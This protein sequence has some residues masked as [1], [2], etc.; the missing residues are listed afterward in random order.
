MLTHL[1]IENFAIIKNT[2]VE[3]HKG[4]NIITGETGS[5]KSIVIEAI[6]IA[7]GGRASSNLVRN[8][9][10][11]AKVQ[12]RAE[13][14]GEEIIIIREISQKG[15]NLCKI[16]G[17]L[18]TVSEVSKIGSILADIHGQYD[19]QILLNQENHLRL[20]DTYGGSDL[21]DTMTK[22]TALFDDYNK[23]KKELEQILNSRQEQNNQ[24]D[25]WK[26]QL[27]E[28]NDARLLPLEDVDL[29]ES[30]KIMEHS[31]TIY[32]NAMNT[33]SLL[34]SDDGIL[35][36]LGK[37]SNYLEEIY[38]FSKD[39]EDIYSQI[40]EAYFS[41]QDL[42]YSLEDISSSLSFSREELDISLSRLHK[43]DS[44]KKKY[45]RDIE[46]ILEYKSDLEKKLE[47]NTNFDEVIDQKQK[48]LKALKE[49]LLDLG[50]VLTSK[51]LEAS[52][53]L[54]NEIEK[55]LKELNFL[56]ARW[57]TELF[58]QN[59]PTS[60]GLEKIEFYIATNKGEI[61]KPLNKTASGGEI[62][63]IML[64]IKKILSEYEPLETMIFDEIDTGI[65]GE[66]AAIVGNKLL[67]I[68]KE[69][70]IICITHLPQISSKAN[71][72]YKISKSISEDETFT[73]IKE[74]DKEEWLFE[75]AR[76]LGGERITESALEN[77]K[78][79]IGM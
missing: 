34:S 22:Y 4:L 78:S 19:N 76:L 51:R 79:L 56:D 62:S 61:P 12:L 57:E 39:I 18:A 47:L 9:E 72:S 50:K 54:K 5:G 30:I 75:T 25:F 63:R 49:N 70:Q 29:E 6:N 52:Q 10:K 15:K 37:C 24:V 26:F 41:L 20:L 43:I 38:S 74:L 7:L 14:D 11:K 44:L 40:N 59:E 71:H 23:A 32:K 28:I 69:K 53:K 77:A 27:K 46:G 1:I 48:K 13:L 73:E 36:S 8:G 16:N 45:G 65:S 60:N 21:L 42:P 35:D 66:T 64:A 67:E 2:E 3:F 68:S 33:F 58:E 17:N 55:E 31:E